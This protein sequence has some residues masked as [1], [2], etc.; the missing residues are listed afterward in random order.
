MV[1]PWCAGD[2]VRTEPSP[3]EA[4]GLPEFD[5]LF[6][7]LDAP[8]DGRMVDG[9]YAELMARINSPTYRRRTGRG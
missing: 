6:A 8:S 4:A 7:Q 5:A 9:G 1:R 2:D 3:V